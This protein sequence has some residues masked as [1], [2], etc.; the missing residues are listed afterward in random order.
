MHH[1]TLIALTLL[2]FAL[3]QTE[4]EM[5]PTYGK[6]ISPN[7]Y[8]VRFY[9]VTYEPDDSDNVWDWLTDF[10]DQAAI[11]I[12]EE[13]A[14]TPKQ[15]AN[16]ASRLEPFLDRDYKD[17][18]K[19]T[20]RIPLGNVSVPMIEGSQHTGL[21][22]DFLE[23]NNPALAV[24]G[25]YEYQAGSDSSTFYILEPTGFT[26]FS[27]IDDVLKETKIFNFREMLENTFLN[28]FVVIPGMP[29]LF[30]KWEGELDNVH[31]HYA[32][33]TPIPLAKT[34]LTW[35]PATYPEGSL[36]MRPLD[37]SDL[38]AIFDARVDQITRYT[39]FFP[40]RKLIMIGDTSSA[41][42]VQAYPEWGK[43]HPNQ[44]ACIFIRNVTHTY[45]EFWQHDVD[46]EETFKGL[47][48]GKWFV[49]NEAS[50]LEKI[51]ITGGSC[52]PTG[53]PDSQTTMSGGYEGTGSGSVQNTFS[54][55]SLLL[56]VLAVVLM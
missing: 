24:G 32:T 28:D 10:L 16:L 49:F 36:D 39:E 14:D 8:S 21:I 25:S 34:Y 33:T 52:R 3:A 11:E 2:S 44:V 31:F 35:L 1:L 45:P 53:I 42:A 43:N 13:A 9:G 29:E 22:D 51:N 12:L 56:L 5:L 37:V 46:L 17:D 30:A 54:L 41:D 15:K 20:F 38:D 7:R 48:R 26:V 40:Q 6:Q 27:D 18:V 55:V 19:T 50:D 47:P 4:F 23:F